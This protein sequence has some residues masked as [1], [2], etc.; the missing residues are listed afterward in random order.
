MFYEDLVHEDASSAASECNLQNPRRP[1]PFNP[2]SST[3]SSF[4]ACIDDSNQ[5]TF[6]QEKD[7]AE[8]EHVVEG[9]TWD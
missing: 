3:G 6:V 4:V 8:E 2:D 5:E 9:E 1:S 7:K